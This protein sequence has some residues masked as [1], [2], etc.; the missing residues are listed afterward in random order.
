MKWQHAK[1]VI[2]CAL[3]VDALKVPSILSKSLQQA[4]LDIVLGLR[5]IL[6]AKKSLKSLTDLDPLEWPTL[7]LV[8][9]RL[10]NEDKYQGAPLKYLNE[11][12]L[13]SCKDQALAD[14]SRLKEKMRERL[15]WSDVPLLRAILDNQA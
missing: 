9:N 15:E 4:K 7:K 11:A 6:Q 2:G 5:S 3:Y 14:L 12:L 13:E 10:K 8:R 1:I